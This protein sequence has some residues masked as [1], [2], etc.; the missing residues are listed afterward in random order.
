MTA[1]SVH[2]LSIDDRV[3]VF[4]CNT[5]YVDRF[6]VWTAITRVRDLDNITYFEHSELEVQRLCDAKLTQY[7]K[8]KIDNYKRQD[9]EAKR[10]VSNEKYIDIYWL[11][12]KID[13]NEYCPLCHCKYSI[14]LD[15]EN[16]VR[17]N[18]IVDHINCELAHKRKTVTYYV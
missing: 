8:L 10:N 3:T 4:D 14:A 9:I 17:C 2:G 5:P 12:N 7:L 1:H 16:N 18:I 11:S 15:E 6:Y 13:K